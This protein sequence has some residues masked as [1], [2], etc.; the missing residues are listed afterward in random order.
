MRKQAAIHLGCRAKG[1]RNKYRP[2]PTSDDDLSLL[3]SE[4]TR[5]NAAAGFGSAAAE[6]LEGEGGKLAASD[7]DPSSSDGQ[8]TRRDETTDVAAAMGRKSGESGVEAATGKKQPRE[9]SHGPGRDSERFGWRPTVSAPGG[10]PR[11][12]WSHVTGAERGPETRL[13]SA[14]RFG[15]AALN[16]KAAARRSP[17]R[18]RP[19][20]R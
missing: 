13:T 11:S 6:G 8:Y 3:D 19:P 9:G 18:T 12:D 1:E 20:W 4:E 14:A 16:G 10:N 17:R 7:D 15:G 5:E 2:R